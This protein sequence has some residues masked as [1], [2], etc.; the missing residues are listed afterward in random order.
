MDLILGQFFYN[1]GVKITK[2]QLRGHKI[3]QK[4]SFLS[5]QKWLNMLKFV[6]PYAID[7]HRAMLGDFTLNYDC[8]DE[9]LSKFDDFYQNFAYY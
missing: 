7:T 4:I 6:K 9:I 1:L 3:G 8:S 2:N 5:L